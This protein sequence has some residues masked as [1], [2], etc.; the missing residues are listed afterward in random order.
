MYVFVTVDWC[1]H[2]QGNESESN[3]DW[4][5]YE[6]ELQEFAVR[7]RHSGSRAEVHIED[8]LESALAYAI[9][10]GAESESTHTLVTGSLHLVGGTLR[11]LTARGVITST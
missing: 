11:D 3:I 10:L 5:R 6:S 1:S 8:S 4:Q 2:N 9:K 7:W